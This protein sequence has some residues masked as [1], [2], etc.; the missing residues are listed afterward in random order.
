MGIYSTNRI[1][2]L[3]SFGE[4]IDFSDP[5]L[6]HGPSLMEA[7]IE[8]CECDQNMF[9][10]L[11][12]FDFMSEN[13]LRTMTESEAVALNEASDKGKISAIIEKIKGVID[14]VIAAIKSGAAKVI[15]KIS[16]IIRADKHIIKKYD[17]TLTL[18]NLSGFKGIKDF[19]LPKPYLTEA[20]NIVTTFS[21]LRNSLKDIESVS[22][23]DLSSIESN[24]D[25]DFRSDIAKLVDNAFN[26]KRD[27]FI[28]SNPE[29]NQIKNGMKNTKSIIGTI[30]K[31]SAKTIN[32]LKRIKGLIK[33]GKKDADG[34]NAAQFKKTYDVVSKYSKNILKG[35]SEFINVLK[36]QLSAYRKAYI[37]CGRYAYN[38]SKEKKGEA[39]EKNENTNEAVNFAITEASDLFVFGL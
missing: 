27:S 29:I 13:N 2:G 23:D 12:E 11:I 26:D 18:E 38:K 4:S 3:S 25:N 8:I 22:V 6:L 21:D 33:S 39:A 28:P 34:E 14:K 19:K 7:C 16:E 15:D 10:T 17:S 35:T 36:K 37:I 24:T 9:E 32:E 5:A 31:S 1:D 20:K 30:K